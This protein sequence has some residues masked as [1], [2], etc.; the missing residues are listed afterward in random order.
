MPLEIPFL[1]LG[2]KVWKEGHA[3]HARSSVVSIV[4]TLGFWSKWLHV[5]PDQ[6]E[7]IFTHR[8]FWFIPWTRRFPFNEIN[9]ITYT[10]SNLFPYFEYS[11]HDSLDKYTINLELTNWSRVV[12]FHWIG[13]GEFS[14]ESYWP[15]WVY[16]KEF[17]FDMTGTQKKESLFFFEI[18]RTIIMGERR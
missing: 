12:L 11:A 15:D 1:S 8:I 17:M 4:L 2:P 7:V 6:R 14:N 16:W 13:E 3:L 5:C 10:Y 9:D 18:I